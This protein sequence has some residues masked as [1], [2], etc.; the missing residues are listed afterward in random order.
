MGLGGL[1]SF[2]SSQISTEVTASLVVY[3]FYRKTKATPLCTLTGYFKKRG[4]AADG[5]AVTL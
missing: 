2:Y 3:A 4:K 1:L 5:W